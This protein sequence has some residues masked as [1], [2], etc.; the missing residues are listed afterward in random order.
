MI[1]KSPKFDIEQASH[2]V[3]AK[4]RKASRLAQRRGSLF[5][6]PWRLRLPMPASA[7]WLACSWTKIVKNPGK[8]IIYFLIC[9]MATGMFTASDARAMHISEGILPFNWAALWF[10]VAAP[11]VA[12]GLYRLAKRSKTDLS[13]KPLVGLM[14]A[15]IFIISCMPIP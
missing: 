14:A 7:L 3:S 1:N 2:S 15:A 8:R 12:G 11:F 5:S 9:F 10:A 6:H 4:F 13:F